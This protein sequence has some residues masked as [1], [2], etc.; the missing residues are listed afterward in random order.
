[1]EKK[2]EQIKYYL[3]SAA[4]LYAALIVD[5]M[6]LFPVD[7]YLLVSLEV[8]AAM[9]IILFFYRNIHHIC[10][11]FLIL[12]LTLL[13]NLY[14][15]YLVTHYNFS[16]HQIIYVA[17]ILS[18]FAFRISGANKVSAKPSPLFYINQ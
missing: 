16:L 14:D 9:T 11:L 10:G 3:L 18:F 17:L 12:N 7:Y 15:G 4:M 2:T 1:M 13:L 8:A 5:V 6:I